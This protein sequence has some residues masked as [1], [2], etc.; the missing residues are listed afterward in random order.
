MI[1][2]DTGFFL[3]LLSGDARAVDVW[4]S[5]ATGARAGVISCITLFELDR[6]AL[7]GAVDRN[8]ADVLLREVPVLCRVVWLDAESGPDLLQRA[9]RLAHGSG[10]SMA[11]ALILAGLLE[12][13]AE[14][15]YTT[16][17][18]LDRYQGATDIIL[19]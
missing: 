4:A 9:A 11:D 7:R 2:F 13:G 15:I 17:R 18:D 19:L 10:L 5:A 1:G 6:L 16:D 8:A 3:R 14:T 12:A